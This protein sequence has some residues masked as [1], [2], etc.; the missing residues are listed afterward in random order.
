ML[1]AYL[2]H[3]EMS[4][5]LVDRGADIAARNLKEKTALHFARKKANVE[6]ERILEAA[7]AS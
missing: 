5:L 1:A 7:G 2:G 3:R 6:V 4:S